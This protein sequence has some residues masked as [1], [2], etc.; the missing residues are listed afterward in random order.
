MPLYNRYSL[1]NFNSRPAF[2][3]TMELK[4]FSEFE[5]FYDRRD[6]NGLLK[7]TSGST[8]IKKLTQLGYL[9]ILEV[10]P[11]THNTQIDY[12]WLYD[13]EISFKGMWLM[14]YVDDLLAQMNKEKLLTK[15]TIKMMLHG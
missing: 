13:I 1:W 9:T 6:S 15:P 7:R 3:K 14:W 2:L 8:S 12:Q 5:W 10:Y 11:P 4:T